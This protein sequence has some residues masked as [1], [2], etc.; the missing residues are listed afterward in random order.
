MFFIIILDKYM[1]IH[2]FFNL[3]NT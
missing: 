1:Y 3:I 2:L